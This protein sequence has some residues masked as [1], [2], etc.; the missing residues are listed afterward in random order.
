MAGM[1]KNDVGGGEMNILA[2]LV[3]Y[4]NESYYPDFEEVKNGKQAARGVDPGGAVD[5]FRVLVL[6]ILASCENSIV[7]K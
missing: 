6:G 4:L 5:L 2:A 1:G 3:R 7:K